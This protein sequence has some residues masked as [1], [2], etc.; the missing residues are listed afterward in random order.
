MIIRYL[1]PWDL[2]LRS[3]IPNLLKLVGALMV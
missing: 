2:R 3:P 1:D